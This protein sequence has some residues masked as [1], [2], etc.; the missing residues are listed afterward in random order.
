MERKKLIDE[1]DLSLEKSNDLAILIYSCWK[2][3]DMWIIFNTLFQKYWKECAYKLILVTDKFLGNA[4]EYDFDD[5]VVLDS[6][7]HDMIM[8]GIEVAGT[9]YVMLWMDDY[10]LCDYVKNDDIEYFLKFAKQYNAANFRLIESATIPSFT[11]DK[12]S[13]L[14]YYVPGTA[15]SMS[16]QV[17]LWNVEFL[18]K[19]VKKEWSAWDFE[20]KGSIEIKDYQHPLLAPK[21]YVFPYEEGVRK[22]KWMVAGA[23]LCQRNGIK[24]DTSVRPIMSNL[25]MAKIY[26]QGAILEWNPTLIVKIQNLFYRFRK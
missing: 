25:E 10:L 16:T 6:N 17:G 12:N 18:K 7:W 24:L 9:P 4:E 1:R 26:F 13:E 8:K 22:G 14:N 3:S 23:M 15:Y 2:N 20:R 5:I 19:N 11:Y 21:E